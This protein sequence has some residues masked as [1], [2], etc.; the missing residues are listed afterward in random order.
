MVALTQSQLIDSFAPRSDDINERERFKKDELISDESGKPPLKETLKAAFT[1]DNIVGSSIVFGPKDRE[2]EDLDFDAITPLRGTVYAPYAKEFIYADNEDESQRVKD[3]IDKEL[4]MRQTL[5]ESGWVGTVSSMAAGVIDPTI[6]IPGTMAIKGVKLGLSATKGAVAGAT[7]TTAAVGVQEAGLHATQHTRTAQESAYAMAFAGMFGG[8]FGGAGAFLTAEGRQ[9][10]K[11][12]MADALAD[13]VVPM[14][15]NKNGEM[16]VYKK[17]A[18]AAEAID[19]ATRPLNLGKVETALLKIPGIRT[20]ISQGLSSEF[21]TTRELT[22]ELFEHNIRLAG[23]LEGIAT[24]TAVDTKLRADDASTIQ[25]AK[26]VR[27]DYVDFVGKSSL[28]ASMGSVRGTN[29]SYKWYSEQLAKAMRRGDEHE[30]PQIAKSAKRMRKEMDKVTKRLQEFEILPKSMEVRGATSY[31]SRVYDKGKIESNHEEFE[32]DIRNYLLRTNRKLS[33]EEVVEEATKIRK[34][35][36]GLGDNTL[37][38]TDVA[39]HTV[40]KGTKFTKERVLLESDE[41]LEKWLINDGVTIPLN[42][43]RQANALIR[44]HELLE[45]KGFTSGNDILS[46][47]ESEFSNAM[48]AAPKNAKKLRK[49][50]NKDKELIKDM[51]SMSLGQYG[52]QGKFDPALRALRKYQILRLL[53]GVVISSI[54][55]M[56]MA[57]LRHGLPRTIMDGY[58]PMIRS[59][60]TSKM[61]KDEFLDYNVGLELLENDLLRSLTDPDYRL[62]QQHKVWEKYLD[63]GTQVFGKATGITYWNSMHKRIA[64]QMSSARTVR[65][66]QAWEKSGAMKPLEEKRLLR[67]G[68]GREHWGNLAREMKN[69]R[70]ESGSFIVN[71]N[72]WTDD[73]TRDVF[74]FSVGK[75]VN[76]T[77]LTPGRGDLPR[78]AQDTE[79][80]KTLFQFKSF[81]SKSTNSIVIPAWQDIKGGGHE[82]ATAVMGIATL[83]ALGTQVYGIKERLAG[84]TPSDDMSVVI[85]EGISRSGVTGLLGDLIIG[86]NPVWNSSRFAGQNAQNI[87]LGPSLSLVDDLYSVVASPFDDQ[88]FTDGDRKRLLRMLP[89]QNL[90]YLRILLQEINNK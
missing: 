55:D 29:K 46:G 86:L 72:Q 3:R 80:G 41:N 20:P 25:L 81:A 16:V 23:E 5:S 14:A 61:A 76:S 82:A 78:W 59:L 73:Q 89:F 75:E 15:L 53:G 40:T 32:L 83:A 51:V 45:A 88:G 47:L 58:L 67:L 33:E 30:I 8:F 9:I 13:N 85:R 54:A 21:A 6:L 38:I 1:V 77:I 22:S 17:S 90:F 63:A 60:K 70:K 7:L 68:V 39:Q 35:I 56:G 27:D 4:D 65:A 84:R 37:Q 50:F 44:Y 19:I 71:L 87:L 43:I 49:Q 48:T 12:L 31:F 26:G 11:S 74:G 10:G 64:G 34:N 2:K 66:I 24:P 62:G 52:R 36:T 79:W 57:V 69:V 18:G 28:S 42:Y